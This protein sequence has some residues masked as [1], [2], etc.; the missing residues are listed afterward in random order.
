MKRLFFAPR[1]RRPLERL[2]RGLLLAGVFALV[3]VAYR[4]NFDT[5][6][7]KAQ[8]KGTVDDPAGV[9]TR[10]DRGWVLQI[11]QEL[12]ARY[13]LNLR[14]RIGGPAPDTAAPG[15]DTATLFADPGCTRSR[16]VL[17]PLAATALPAGFV[18]DLGREHLDAACRDG[19]L[20][21]G[22]LAALGLLTESLDQAAGRGKGATH[23]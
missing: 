6:I 22:V 5:V 19:R 15:H 17:A 10:D 3:V 23:E 14:L 13:G 16:V 2:A 12:R 4:K 1:G 9:L 21:E 20:R 18:D 11:A 7:E 8:A